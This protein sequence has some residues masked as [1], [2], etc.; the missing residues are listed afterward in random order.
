MYRYMCTGFYESSSMNRLTDFL[1][2]LHIIL[3]F[4]KGKSYMCMICFHID[5]YKG[6]AGRNDV[7][8][9]QKMVLVLILIE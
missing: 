7:L 8:K 3:K 2:F 4:K 1:T 6:I 5:F 9:K